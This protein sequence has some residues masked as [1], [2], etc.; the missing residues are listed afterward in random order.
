MRLNVCLQAAAGLLAIVG[1]AACSGQVTPAEGGGGPPIPIPG[2]G[3]MGG[4]PGPGPAGPGGPGG[5]MPPATVDSGLPCKPTSHAFAPARL[6]QLTDRQYMNVVRDVFGIALSEEDGR[7]VSAGAADRYTNYSEGIAIDTQVAPNYQTAALKVADL[8]EA[9][10]MTLLGSPAPTAQQVADFVTTKIARAFRRPLSTDEV[11]A[12][13]RLYVSGQPDGPGRGFHLLME[14]ALQA[15]SFLYRTELGQGAAAATGPVQLT[16]HELAS[17][18]SFLFLESAPDDSLWAKA[19]DGSLNTPAV[20]EAEIDRILQLPAVKAN[21]TQKAFYWLGLAGIS[22]RSRK[23]N[24]YPEWNENV[25]AALTQS[26]R[27]FLGEIIS[28]G[29]LSDLFT[30]NRI[31]LNRE[32]SRLYGIP[33]PGSGGGGAMPP[34]PA[35]TLVPV[36]VPGTERSAGI[37]SQ[38]GLLVAANKLIDRADVVHRGLMMND[39]FVCGGAVPPAPPEAGDEAKKMDGTERERA[40]ARAAKPNCLPCHQ[41]FDPLGLTFERYDAIGRYT[42]TRQAVLDSDTSVTSWQMTTMPVDASAVLIE[43]GLGGNLGGPVNGLNELAAK[44]TAASE[45]VGYCASRK[46]AEYSLGFNPDA[47][48]SC[49][50]KAVKQTFI[51]TGSFMEFWKALA[52]SP[53]FRTRNPAAPAGN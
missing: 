23:A 31:F 11:T 15:P 36:A 12:L 42:E 28:S 5:G 24:L 3:G 25:K 16:P 20:L 19:Q 45:R 46:L 52:L 35:G 8:A 27:L 34:M 14:A 32:L 21:L 2:M 41:K 33:L 51:K 4:R 49:E 26:V 43:D 9:R 40:N 22:N 30:S 10:M 17:A 50:M 18:V 29:K 47:E 39:A 48:N 7:I 13:V 37:L 6:W 53:G 38:P 1:S 44:L